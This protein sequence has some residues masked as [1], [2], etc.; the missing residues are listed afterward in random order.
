MSKSKR[1]IYRCRGSGGDKARKQNEENE[2]MGEKKGD[3]ARTGNITSRGK[4]QA[5]ME[6]KWQTSVKVYVQER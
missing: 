5:Q 6:R 3:S 4:W 2:T 1:K